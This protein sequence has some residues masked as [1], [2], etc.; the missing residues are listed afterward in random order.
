MI[1]DCQDRP[2]EAFALKYSGKKYGNGVGWASVVMDAMHQLKDVFRPLTADLLLG[3]YYKDTGFED[4]D[5][6]P[7][8]PAFFLRQL[9]IP[10]NVYAA[11]EFNQ[12]IA[13]TVVSQIPQI[14]KES[15]VTWVG[16]ALE[17]KSPRP[18]IDVVDVDRL[19]F[20]TVRARVFNEKP[21]RGRNSFVVDYFRMGK[22]E[23]PLEKIDEQ[24]WVYSPLSQ[25]YTKSAFHVRTSFDMSTIRIDIYWDWWTKQSPE[26]EVLE[27][28]MFNIINT[29]QWQLF[30]LNKYLEMPRL[31]DL[32][33]D[34]FID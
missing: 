15:V 14:N 3:C 17:Q 4:W 34:R 29:G 33:V 11:P 18:D 7:N 9:D 1:I 8:T 12:K 13:P 32:V 28:A 26:K 2:E 21:F 6:E 19:Y 27:Q 22:Y 30:Y 23:Y 16:K 31:K 10:E 25:T 20:R 24:L 5:A